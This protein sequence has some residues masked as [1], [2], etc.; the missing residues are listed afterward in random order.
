MRALI[1]SDIHANMQA[2]AAVLAAAPEHDV[3]WNLGDVV[4]Y[5][6][7][8][9]ETIVCL[10]ELNSLY[11]RG[12]HDR[13]CCGLVSLDEPHTERRPTPEQ[14]C[15]LEV[16]CSYATQALRDARR[17]RR[18]VNERAILS[19]IAEI[20]PRISSCCRSP[21]TTK[22]RCAASASFSPTRTI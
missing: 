9:N 19:R 6:A 16:I 12:N 10:K 14:L 20:S 18:R 2:L 11:V 15:L 22:P 21:N 1:L 8:P 17:S 3:V 5:G 7:S 4:G 13:A